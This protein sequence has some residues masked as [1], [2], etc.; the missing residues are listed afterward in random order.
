MWVVA[1]A[2]IFLH[3]IIYSTSQIASVLVLYWW[4]EATD[5]PNTH[6]TYNILG[7]GYNRNCKEGNVLTLKNHCA[8]QRLQFRHRPHAACL[9]F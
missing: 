7:K 2:G 5:S 4:N 8:T 3:D 6:I 1:K 9:Y